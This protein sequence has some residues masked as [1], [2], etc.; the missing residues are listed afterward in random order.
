MGTGGSGS[1]G[2]GGTPCDAPTMV[3]KAKCGQVICHDPSNTSSNAG[4]DFT[5]STGYVAELLGKSSQGVGSSVCGSSSMPYLVEG[6]NP[7]AGLFIDKIVNSPP[8]CGVQMPYGMTA[9][10][11]SDLTCVKSWALGITTGVITQ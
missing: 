8:S 10:A 6:S 11:G 3:L 7:A 5:K 2:S 4:L 1:G 9:L